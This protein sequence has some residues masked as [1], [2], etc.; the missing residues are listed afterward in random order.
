MHMI[1]NAL[2][3]RQGQRTT[4]MTAMAPIG[5]LPP[6]D[7]PA[8]ELCSGTLL[9]WSAAA[10]LTPALQPTPP[11]R[12]PSHTCCATMQ[13]TH[14][15]S[16]LGRPHIGECGRAQW[17]ATIS[18]GMCSTTLG[19]ASRAPLPHCKVQG[20]EGVDR[21]G[22]RTSLGGRGGV[23]HWHGVRPQGSPRH[24]RRPRRGG[25]RRR[26]VL[27]RRRQL[28]RRQRLR[29]LCVR[30]AAAREAQLR[31]GGQSRA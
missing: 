1:H 3:P 28:R 24:Q 16:C 8:D 11:L 26:A 30:R 23:G 4:T 27:R 5:S 14:V 21:S 7:A 13:S 22:A 29:V 12:T 18:L 20:V 10:P 15:C 25:G 6:P 31:A 2:L 19:A 9:L 17:S